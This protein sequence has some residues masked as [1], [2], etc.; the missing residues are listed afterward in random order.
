MSHQENQKIARRRRRAR[1]SQRLGSGGRPPPIRF[2]P[3]PTSQFNPHISAFPVLAS[4]LYPSPGSSS[5]N[6]TSIRWHRRKVA[7]G[8]SAPFLILHS[9]CAR[10]SGFFSFLSPVSWSV[11]RLLRGRSIGFGAR[12][13]ALPQR[14]CCRVLIGF[15]T[16]LDFG[17]SNFCWFAPILG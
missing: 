10:D 8:G 9:I 13:P 16:G 1:A 6:S 2:A 15:L 17:G 4:P 14:L 12:G 3:S 7:K 11:S 5:Y